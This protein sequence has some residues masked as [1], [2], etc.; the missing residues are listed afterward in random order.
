MP[1][2]KQAS[3]LVYELNSLWPPKH[4]FLSNTC[5][6]LGTYLTIIALKAIKLCDG[7]VPCN[8]RAGQV[9]KGMAYKCSVKLSFCFVLF[10]F[11]SI[12]VLQG[13]HYS[14]G[15]KYQVWS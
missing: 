6:M 10:C 1:K 5:H 15:L 12:W 13:P 3:E 14:K 8:A 7:L 2:I 9:G 4:M 11:L